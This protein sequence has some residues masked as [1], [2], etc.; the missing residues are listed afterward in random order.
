MVPG[1]PSSLFGIPYDRPVV[2]YGGKNINTLRLWA[3]GGAGL[4]RFSG[5]R[6]GRFRGCGGGDARG[7]IAHPRA[8]SR[9]FDAAGQGLRFVQEYFLVACSLADL[10]RRFRAHNTDWDM[11]PEKAAIQ[12][13]D[14]HPTMAVPELMR[15]LLDDAHLG[16]DEAWDIDQRRPGLHQPHAAARG[17]GEMAGGVV[18]VLLPRQLGNH[19]RD[20]PAAARRRFGSRF[21]GDGDAWS[22]SASWRRAPRKQCAWPTLPS[23]ARTA[24]TAW[25]RSIPDCCARPP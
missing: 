24:P 16:W 12:L 5:I 18:R 15:I 17:A 11:L 7:G 9:R 6:H 23:S 21:P 14:T 19:L 10:I 20:Q 8:V 1:R 13:N 3:A 4:L 22:A 25:R 2:G